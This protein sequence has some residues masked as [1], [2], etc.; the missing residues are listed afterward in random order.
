MN[1][2]RTTFFAHAI[3][4]IGVK[5]EL[6]EKEYED[7]VMKNRK[8]KINSDLMNEQLLKKRVLYRSA[9]TEAIILASDNKVNKKVI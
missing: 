1:E 6:G 9:S 3:K 8:I 7:Y 2:R 4:S 5:R